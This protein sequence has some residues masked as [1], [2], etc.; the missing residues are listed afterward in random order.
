MAK[1]K[2]D[3]TFHRPIV[4][5]TG[6]SRGIGREIAKQFAQLGCIVCLSGRNKKTLQSVV[7]EIIKYGG[8]AAA[9]SLDITQ[10]NAIQAVHRQIQKS[11]GEVDVLIN[12]AGISSFKSFLETPLKDFNKIIS[13]NLLGHIACTKAVLPSMVKRKKGWIFNIVSMVAVKTYDDSSAYTASKA[14]LFGCGKVLREEMKMHGV[15]VVNVLPGATA[16]EIWHPKVREKYSSRMMKAKSVAE[17]VL[18]VFQMPDDVVVDEIVVRPVKG[19]L[20]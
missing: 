12:N 6:A 4:W 15:K 17:A 8:K 1:K 10:P 7:K 18:A 11:I 16:T 5:V 13:T 3:I 14:G 9:F 20:S 19:D 2:Q